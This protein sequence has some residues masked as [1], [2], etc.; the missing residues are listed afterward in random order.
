MA[1]SCTV[2]EAKRR[3][4]MREFVQWQAYYRLEP[5]GEERADLRN[6]IVACVI[7]N[8]HRGKGRSFR[9]RDFMPTFDRRPQQTPQEME[10][11]FRAFAARH[12]AS[13]KDE[14]HGNHH[15]PTGR[16]PER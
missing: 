11:V 2:A 13:L 16:H 6:A 14:R 1:W 7:A 12:N 8:A 10:T 5:F 15:R 3:C 4:T 9:V